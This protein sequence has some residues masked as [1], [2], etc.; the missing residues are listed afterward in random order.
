[1]V[2]LARLLLINGEI[3]P[4]R[5]QAHLTIWIKSRQELNSV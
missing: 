2:A 3:I 5:S 4:D 1:M